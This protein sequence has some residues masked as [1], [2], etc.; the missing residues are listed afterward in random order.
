M[1]ITFTLVIFVIV[2]ITVLA[3]LIVVVKNS[4]PFL[5]DKPILHFLLI[6][7]QGVAEWLASFHGIQEVVG[8]V[9]PA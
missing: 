6:E 8:L 3:I 7:G 4:S 5:V 2:I 1:V 9:M